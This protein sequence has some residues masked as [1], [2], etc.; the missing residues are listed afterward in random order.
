MLGVLSTCSPLIKMFAKAT[1]N[2][3]KDIDAGGDLIPVYS[4]NDSDKAHL[5]G[6]VAKTRRFWCWQK[7]KYHFSSCSCTLSDIMTEDKEIKPVVVESEFVKYEGTFGDVIKGNIGAEV[8]ALQM[9]ASGCGYVESQSSFGTLRKQEVDMQ[10]LMKDVHDRRINLHHPF[11]KQL[12]ENKN[13]VLCILKEKIVTTQKCIITEHTQTEETFKG[14]V[15]MKA[16]IVKVSVSENGN[17]LK[18]E[19]TILEIPPPTA[20]AYGVVELY[21]K[22]NGTFDFC[23]LSEKKGGFEKENLEKHQHSNPL[24]S[25]QLVLFDWDVVDGSKEA[26]VRKCIL[27]SA[28]LC[29]LREGI[30]AHEKHFSAWKQLPDVQ[31]LELYTL[32][33]QILYDGQALSKLHAVV[34]DLCSKRKPTQAAFDELMPSQRIIAENILYLSGYDM[35]NGKF[36]HAANRELLVALHIL[37]SALNELS[38]S[39]LAVLGTCCELQLLPVFSALMNMS[40]DEGLCSTTEPALMDFLDQERFYVSQKLFALFNIELEIKEDFIYAATAEDPGF[41]PL[42][43]FIVITGLQLLKRD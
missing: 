25:D 34:E 11:I 20:I 30:A 41:L 39:A 36:L 29:L 37:T 35:P 43:L 15:S 6:V 26:F 42:I 33:C 31:C 24:P 1:K 8:G 4:L 14:K 5:L 23:L 32:L 28:P 10:H 27:R 17:Y 16:K 2:F 13:D 40:S 22:H 38:D 21:I 12:Q 18:D 7:P 3:L 19:N 9:N